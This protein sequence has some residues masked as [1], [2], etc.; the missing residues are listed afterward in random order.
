M[1]PLWPFATR[2]LL[3]KNSGKE[4]AEA[5]WKLAQEASRPGGN[6]GSNV[7]EQEPAATTP[8]K[9]AAWPAARSHGVWFL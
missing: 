4:F 3:A 2:K 9:A 6:E 5:A 1:P 7:V 8:K